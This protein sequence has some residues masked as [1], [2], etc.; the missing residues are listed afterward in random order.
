MKEKFDI[1]EGYDKLRKKYNLPDFDKLD[2]EFEISNIKDFDKKFILRI[3]RRM[4]NDKIIAFCNLLEGVV[5]P[6][7]TS[8][9]GLHENSFFDDEKKKSISNFLSDL[10]K[11]ER[12]SL[13]L[14]IDFSDDKDA[15][16]INSVFDKWVGIKG[17]MC[18]VAKDMSLG[19]EKEEKRMNEHYFG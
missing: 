7:P 17:F 2:N 1:K 9:I 6:N 15:E 8:M 11:L 3:I 13:V 5:L 14:D 4:I 12:E 10:M 19:W 18:E 16:F